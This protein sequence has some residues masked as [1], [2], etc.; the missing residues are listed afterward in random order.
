MH[1]LFSLKVLPAVPFD[2]LA[3][4]GALSPVLGV[5]R[6]GDSIIDKVLGRLVPQV[7]TTTR[8]RVV[9]AAVYTRKKELFT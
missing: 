6:Y 9:V 7:D 2:E 1:A 8:P 4:D 3:V 5:L